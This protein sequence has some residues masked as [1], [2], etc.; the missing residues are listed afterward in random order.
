MFK[1][2]QIRTLIALIGGASVGSAATLAVVFLLPINSGEG[3]KD[4]RADIPTATFDSK[5]AMTGASISVEHLD[6][7]SK[8]ST[9]FERKTALFRL[10]DKASEITLVQLLDESQNLDS[11]HLRRRHD[12]SEIGFVKS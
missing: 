9:D 1:S 5:S 4:W 6:D 8:L 11:E 7:I 2:N 3:T 12:H 10:L